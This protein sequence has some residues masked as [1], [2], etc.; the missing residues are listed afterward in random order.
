MGLDISDTECIIQWKLSDYLTMNC[1]WQHAGQADRNPNIWA[2]T[3]LFYK[4]QYQLSEDSPLHGNQ[5]KQSEFVKVKDYIGMQAVMAT[6]ADPSRSKKE[7][8]SHMLW[9]IRKK[10]VRPDAQTAS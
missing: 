7:R 1:W 6:T 8:E 4:P 9:Y 5:D 3:I 2:I 10:N